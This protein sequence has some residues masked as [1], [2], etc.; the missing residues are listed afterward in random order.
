METPRL[1]SSLEAM[2]VRSAEYLCSSAA[3]HDRLS[4]G[5]D[6]L[7]LDLAVD[8]H[9]LIIASGSPGGSISVTRGVLALT[10]NRVEISE[11]T[12]RRLKGVRPGINAHHHLGRLLGRSSAS[13]AI[14]T[15]F[16]AYAELVRMTAG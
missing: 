1:A 2:P 8:E 14:R 12:A 11:A 10:E 6:P 16:S 3:S 4:A 7:I 15:K 9:A 13:R 5:E